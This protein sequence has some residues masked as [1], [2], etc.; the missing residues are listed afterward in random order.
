MERAGCSNGSRRNSLRGGET[1]RMHEIWT[2][3]GRLVKRRGMVTFVCVESISIYY[4][5]PSKE[6][7]IWNNVM[8]L[9]DHFLFY[10]VSSSV[11]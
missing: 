9:C 4:Y 5:N 10:S 7:D 1:V 8:T 3:V 11:K 6:N 2:Y